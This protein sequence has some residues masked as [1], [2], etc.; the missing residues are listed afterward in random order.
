MG[1]FTQYA[2]A[3]PVL[4]LAV[5]CGREQTPAPIVVPPAPDEDV[6][7]EWTIYGG[8]LAPV[9]RFELR[10]ERRADGHFRYAWRESLP[11]SEGGW[12]NVVGT[13]RASST[14]SLRF[15]LITEGEPQRVRSANEV[16]WPF[17]QWSAET[18]VLLGN[19]QGLWKTPPKWTVSHIDPTTGRFT[20]GIMYVADPRYSP[21]VQR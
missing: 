8:E 1:R 12:R 6:V 20:D 15:D 18:I 2:V 11:D 3:L 7:L 13:W 4:L 9:P 16:E 17:L 21:T 19:G 10:L 14:N 5:A